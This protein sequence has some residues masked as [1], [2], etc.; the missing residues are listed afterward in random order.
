[1]EAENIEAVYKKYL[2]YFSEIRKRLLVLVLIFLTSA[3]IGFV[4][5]EKIVR[6]V[7]NLLELN[8]VNVVFTSPF[9][10]LELAVSCGILVGTTITLPVVIYNLLSFIRSALTKKEY[11]TI[12]TMIPFSAA[13][14]LLGF[15][16][17]FMIMRYVVMIFYEKSQGLNIGN[18]LD[19]TKLLSQ[20]LIT[21]GLM[22]IAFQFP[23]VMTLLIRLKVVSRKFFASQRPF[24]Y[25]LSILFAALLPPTDI[26]S[27]IILTVPLV[28]L[29]ESTLLLNSFVKGR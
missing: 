5:Y 22:G 13:L 4:Y 14:F 20:I 27:L 10:F 28:F 1:M 19:V 21:S 9:Q 11:K 2:P 25:G 18:F 16:T 3:I 29:F 17:G 8:G 6:F 24:A 7:L 15:G 12:K 23:I 26:L